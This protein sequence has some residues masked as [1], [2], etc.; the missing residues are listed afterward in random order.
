MDSSVIDNYLE[1]VAEPAQS[2]FQTVRAMIHEL[3]PDVQ[4]CVSYGIP[5]FR[6]PGG[7]VAGIAVNKRFCSYYPFSGSV[8]DQ[9][10]DLLAEYSHTKSALHFP[11]DTPLPRQLVEALLHARIKQLSK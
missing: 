2:T 3:V 5:A 7:V 8:L 1:Q 4:E 6:T 9:L 10:G 11:F